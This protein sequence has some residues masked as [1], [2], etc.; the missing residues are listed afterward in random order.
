MITFSA[1]SKHSSPSDWSNNFTGGRSSEGYRVLVC[2]RVRKFNFKSSK[3]EV[4]NPSWDNIPFKRFNAWVLEAILPDR[5]WYSWA[6]FQQTARRGSRFGNKNRLQKQ[7]SPSSNR[8]PPG[9]TMDFQEFYI[10]KY[11]LEGSISRKTN[12]I[13]FSDSI[14]LSSRSTNHPPILVP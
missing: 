14:L 4:C 10:F 8:L 6:P 5:W 12:R 1:I 3:S 11:I 13:S 2:M 7:A 9:E